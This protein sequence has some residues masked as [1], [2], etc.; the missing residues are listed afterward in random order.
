VPELEKEKIKDN[1][2]KIKE[3]KEKI[4]GTQL[5]YLGALPACG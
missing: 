3:N 2:G 4:K 1:K 5:F